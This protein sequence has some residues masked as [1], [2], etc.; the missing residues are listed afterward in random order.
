MENKNI[1]AVT[2]AFG[3]SGKYIA[4]LLLSE[5]QKVITLTN[6]FN[7]PN[8]FG[9]KVKA[10]PFNFDKKEDLVKSLLEVKVLYNTYW[11]RF[12]HKTFKHS[13]AVDNTL[14]LF[15]AAK[16]AGVEK[17]VHVSITNPS[18]ESHLEYFNGK[19]I[20]EKA[21]INSGISYSILR[22][23]VIF[24]QEDILINNIAWMIRNMPIMGVFGDGKYRLQPIYVNDLA[25]IAVEQG[26]N[27]NN[28]I[29][30]AIGPETFEYKELIETIAKIL[31]INRK[32]IS[33]SDNF[34]YFVG[35]IIGFFKNDYLI[36]KPEIE[37]LK[38][39]LLYTKSQPAGKTKLTEWVEK[40]KK[41]LG[42]IYSNELKRRKEISKSYTELK[43]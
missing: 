25:Q 3:Y 30:D 31:G 7:R 21:L 18:K 33:V 11:V 4:E 12:N 20:L 16:K 5:N 29:I 24:G 23:T 14:I 36:T 1:H 15:E 39:D 28:I 35:K 6:S 41:T 38:S 37:G 43:K 42:K 27:S 8:L 9:E 17:I 32:I 19:A 2:G 40:N 13:E 10:F 22:P 26:K 34:G